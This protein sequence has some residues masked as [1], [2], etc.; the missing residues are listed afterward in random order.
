MRQKKKKTSKK[1]PTEVPELDIGQAAAQL[2]ESTD[3]MNES[4]YSYY[5]ERT[6]AETE[7]A[8]MRSL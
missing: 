7:N 6:D 3:Q 8:N 2:A 5:T 1:P 4:M